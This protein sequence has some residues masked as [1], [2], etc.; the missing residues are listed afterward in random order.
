MYLYI[1]EKNQTEKKEWGIQACPRKF[2]VKLKE[3]K[4]SIKEL[5]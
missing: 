5:K 2:D 4:A 3:L 1:S